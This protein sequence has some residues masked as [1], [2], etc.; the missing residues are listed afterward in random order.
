MAI[1]NLCFSHYVNGKKTAIVTYNLYW[2]IS[3][4]T[5]ATWFKCVL[6]WLLT[7]GRFSQGERKEETTGVGEEC[8]EKRW[9]KV[10]MTTDWW[11]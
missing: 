6:P 11:L 4:V 9:Q 5:M 3:F 8:E 7:G 2:I 1:R 10:T